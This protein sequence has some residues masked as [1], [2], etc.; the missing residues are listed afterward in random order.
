MLTRLG[1]ISISSV[2]VRTNKA[3]CEKSQSSPTGSQ[4]IF[5]Y[6][7]VQVRMVQFYFEFACIRLHSTSNLYFTFPRQQRN[8]LHTPA[9]RIAGKCCLLWQRQLYFER[10]QSGRNQQQQ[11]QHIIDKWHF[12]AEQ[13]AFAK[14]SNRCVGINIH[15][16]QCGHQCRQP[17]RSVIAFRLITNYGHSCGC[18]ITT[19]SVDHLRINFKVFIVCST[20]HSRLDWFQI[21]NKQWLC[22]SVIDA[23][24]LKLD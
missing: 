15:A 7:R 2:N 21:V 20:N 11:F 19:R 5:E 10:K 4:H 13:C 9:G 8:L 18:Q 17:Q 1:G 12:I 16:N 6:E 3:K 24:R 23:S 14:T 22:L